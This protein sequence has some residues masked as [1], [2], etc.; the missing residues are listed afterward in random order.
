M[1]GLML[2]LWMGGPWAIVLLTFLGGLAGH[3][4]DD[5][6]TFHDPS[7]LEGLE[8]SSSPEPSRPPVTREHSGEQARAQE[9]RRSVPSRELE[10]G[11]SDYALLG[12]TPEASDAEVKRAYRRLAAA[13]HPD[14]VAH[15][16]SG[17]VEQATRRFQEL[18]DAYRNL[19]RLR[20]LQ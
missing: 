4:Y 14:R 15:L 10:T 2:G 11:E 20:G 17:A 18:Q 13:H 7:P 5:S 19:Q 12:L 16:G 6:H 1:L 8:D 9:D 3:R